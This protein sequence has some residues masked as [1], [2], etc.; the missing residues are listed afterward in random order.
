MGSLQESLFGWT[1]GSTWLSLDCVGKATL[2]PLPGCQLDL[3]GMQGWEVSRGREGEKAW[4][5]CPGRLCPHCPLAQL[6]KHWN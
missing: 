5:R 1:P 3:K 4:N 2:P 6:D